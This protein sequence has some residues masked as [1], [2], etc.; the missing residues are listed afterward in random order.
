MSMQKIRLIYLTV[1]V[2]VGGV[3]N[4]LNLKSTTKQSSQIPLNEMGSLGE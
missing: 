2:R 3:L 1:G 4:R